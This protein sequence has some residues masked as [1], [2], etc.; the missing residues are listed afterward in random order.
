MRIAAPAAIRE[1]ECATAPRLT[2]MQRASVQGAQAKPPEA[3]P[4]V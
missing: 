3:A 4:G 2:A 1:R